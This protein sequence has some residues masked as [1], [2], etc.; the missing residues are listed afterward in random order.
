MYLQGVG[1][2]SVDSAQIHNPVSSEKAL[3]R[4]VVVAR[5][6]NPRTW[7]SE[8]GRFLSSRPA[9]S[10]ELSSMTA[11]SIQKIPFSKKNKK[12]NKHQC[13]GVV[14]DT[15]NFNTLETET[16]AGRYLGV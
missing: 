3:F 1:T 10:I 8:A 15:F 11:R 6:F 9:W 16:E 7:E 12:K 14:V 13:T 2:S 4:Q 5:T